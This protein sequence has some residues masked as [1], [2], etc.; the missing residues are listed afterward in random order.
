M[1][2]DSPEI[3][4]ELAVCLNV[5]DELPELVPEA[6]HLGVEV[7]KDALDLLDFRRGVDEPAMRGIDLAGE[8]FGRGPGP[9]LS[10]RLA[11]VVPEVLGVR[12]HPGQQGCP[13]VCRFL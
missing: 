2:L 9:G 7:L 4:R 5:V 6:D 11:D 13:G 10:G 12:V 3:R 1:R 8:E